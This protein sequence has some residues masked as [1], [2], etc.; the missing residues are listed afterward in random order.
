MIL[1]REEKA[2]MIVLEQ[3]NRQDYCRELDQNHWINRVIQEIEPLC[4]NSTE[5]FQINIKFAGLLY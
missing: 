5:L 4:I 1:E 3:Q 2:E